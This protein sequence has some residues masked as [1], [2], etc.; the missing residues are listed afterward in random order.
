MRRISRA[1][2]IARGL[3]RYFTGKPCCHD[4][5]S[6]RR[7]N[8]A[9]CILCETIRNSERIKSRKY[10]EKAR[11]RANA[12]YKNNADQCNARARR[13]RKENPDK[14]LTA[15]RRY[16]AQNKDKVKAWHARYL[17]KNRDKII[18]ARRRYRARH[19]ER[20]RLHQCEYGFWRKL[21]TS[22]T[23]L[24]PHT[25]KAVQEVIAVQRSL[26]DFQRKAK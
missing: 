16:R 13:Y 7:C 6:E 2:A 24:N 8:S 12:Y 18:A 22:V 14:V 3:K 11:Q 21:G 23:R 1:E 9:K 10:Y 15:K 17:K 5:I 20:A 26:H 4:H 25:R 19:L